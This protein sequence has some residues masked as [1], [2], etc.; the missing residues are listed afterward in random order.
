MGKGGEKEVVVPSC[1]EHLVADAC[2]TRGY[3]QGI[4]GQLADDGEVLRGMVLSAATGVLVEQDIE[5]PMQIVRK[6][7]FRCTFRF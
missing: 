7:E 2:R 3:L 6:R 4:E 5:D 1:L